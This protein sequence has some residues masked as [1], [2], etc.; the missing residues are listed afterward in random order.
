VDYSVTDTVDTLD[1]DSE[2]SMAEKNGGK[3]AN[4]VGDPKRSGVSFRDLEG[5][6]CFR[7][8]HFRIPRNTEFY[9]ELVLFRVIPRN[10]LLF[11][12][13]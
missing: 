7:K 9:T 10:F 12:S 11:N 1:F 4:F 13:V 2:M 6:G 5:V 8:C 3:L